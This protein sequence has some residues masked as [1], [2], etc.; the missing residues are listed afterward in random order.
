MWT[1]LTLLF[2]VVL[3]IGIFIR[4]LLVFNREKNTPVQDKDSS[5]EEAIVSKKKR[6]K[7]GDKAEVEKLYKRA[8]TLIT[9]GDE[10]EAIK[11]LVQALAIDELNTDIQHRLAMLYMQKQVFGAAAALFETLGNIT[12]EAVHYS[13]QGLACFQNREL[14]NAKK[15][16][17]KAVSIDPSRHQRFASL[18]T[19]YRELNELQNAIIS[20]NKAIEIDKE[21][22]DYLFVLVDL[23]VEVG[24]LD[25]AKKTLMA[26]RNISS[27]N[28][29]V[30]N[31]IK[32]IEAM[33]SIEE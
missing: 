11:I 29:D 24:D 7:K 16:Y 4:R 9:N 22:M 12:G 5:L 14:E 6:L 32:R 30:D 20:I 25:G 15:A 10:D 1:Y 21:N 18:S 28:F 8:E 19:V 33:S 17:Q 31:Y 26:L 23:L 13:H 27:D 2:S 3:F